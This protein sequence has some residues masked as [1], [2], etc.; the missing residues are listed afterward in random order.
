MKKAIVILVLVVL[1]SNLSC[2]A[3]EADIGHHHRD[4]PLQPA[5]QALLSE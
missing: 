4:G 2:P 3:E 1:M 5:L